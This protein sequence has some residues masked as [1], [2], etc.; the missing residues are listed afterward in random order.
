MSTLRISLESYSVLTSLREV[1]RLAS[2]DPNLYFELLALVKE[3]FAVTDAYLWNSRPT[4]IVAPAQN[5]EAKIEG[6]RKKFK[7]K[8]MQLLI[9][10]EGEGLTLHAVSVQKVVPSSKKFLSLNRPLLLFLATIIT[11]SITGYFNAKS[12]VDILT[13]LGRSLEVDEG[14]YLLGMTAAYT[15]SIMAVLGLHEIGHLIACRRHN[16][17]ASW[18]I[19]IPGIPLLT[20]GTFGALIRQKQPTL[21]RN[22]LFDIGFSGPII[23]FIIALVVSLIGYSLSIPLSQTEYLLL[24][25]YLGEGQ[26]IFIPFLFQSLSP[27]IFPNS[28]SFTHILHPL[29]LAGWV[30]TLLTFLNIFPIGQLDGGHVSR[31]LFGAK[32]HRRFSYVMTLV[33]ILTGWWSMA[34]LTLLFLRNKHPGTMDDTTGVSTGRK[35]LSILVAVIFISCF[36]LTPDS[37]LLYLLTS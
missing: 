27:Y 35:I 18:P 6:L 2:M 30:A 3:E 16:I 34:L 28:T 20:L 29:A 17:E 22:Q 26:Y 1:E 31:A 11:V 15:I 32:W 14:L 19:F 13:F 4:F 33:M 5:L 21:N 7:D 12:F 25:T 10:R 36:T 9:R 8:N 37:P 24:T 23:G